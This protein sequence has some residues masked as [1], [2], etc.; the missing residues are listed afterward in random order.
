MPKTKRGEKS[1]RGRKQR[2]GTGKR[3]KRG[4]SDVSADI[5]TLASP[6]TEDIKKAMLSEMRASG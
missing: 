2:K 4:N 5:S 3:R 1:D 6:N